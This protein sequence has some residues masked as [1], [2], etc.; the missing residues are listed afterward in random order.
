M[1]LKIS[2]RKGADPAGSATGAAPRRAPSRT[3]GAVTATTG[4]AGALPAPVAPSSLDEARVNALT[5]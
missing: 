3:A 4:F 2:G 5:E 1:E